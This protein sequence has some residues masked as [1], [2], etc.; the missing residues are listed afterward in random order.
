[1]SV[2]ERVAFWLYPAAYI[3]PARLAALAPGLDRDLAARLLG[4]RRL[5]FRLSRWISARAELPGG[6]PPEESPGFALARQPAAELLRLARACGALLHHGAVRSVVLK[7]ERQELRAFLGPDTHELALKRAPFLRLPPPPPVGADGLRAAVE[8]DGL[9]CL[10]ARFAVEPPGLGGR[11]A[12]KLE[13]GAGY[14]TPVEALAG[15]AGRRV[16]ARVCAEGDAA[17]RAFSS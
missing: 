4:T 14:D 8:R 7:Q 15:E 10:R 6:A 12:L 2:G 16:L 13:P 11:V 9:A 3:L 5:A 17:W 1:M